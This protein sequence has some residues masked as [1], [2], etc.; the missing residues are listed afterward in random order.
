MN[1]KKFSFE[2][3]SE[4]CHMSVDFVASIKIGNLFPPRKGPFYKQVCEFSRG[5]VS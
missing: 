5:R 1:S 3:L 2:T 4:I